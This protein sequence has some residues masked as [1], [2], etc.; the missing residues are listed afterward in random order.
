VDAAGSG[1]RGAGPAV[2]L[3]ACSG[4]EGVPVFC[5]VPISVRRTVSSLSVAGEPVFICADEND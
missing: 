4:I 2:V 5:A 1:L 3:A